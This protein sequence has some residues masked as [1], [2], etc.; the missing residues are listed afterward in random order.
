M[1]EGP[2]RAAPALPHITHSLSLSLSRSLNCRRARTQTGTCPYAHTCTKTG[3]A[4]LC[5]MQALPPGCHGNLQSVLPWMSGCEELVRYGWSPGWVELCCSVP[6]RAVL[7]QVNR[8][9]N[10]RCNG[11]LTLLLFCMAGVALL[12]LLSKVLF[13]Y[14]LFLKKKK[15]TTIPSCTAAGAKRA[16][17]SRALNLA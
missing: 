15:T 11:F 4:S 16:V 3:P 12:L 10:L 5:P 9:H 7:L 14:L 1:N 13:L 6:R 2:R 17:N 8:L